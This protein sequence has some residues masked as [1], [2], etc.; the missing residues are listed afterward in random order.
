MR[1]KIP[2]LILGVFYGVSFFAQEVVSTAGSIYNVNGVQLSWTI[3]EPI[4][5]TEDDGNHVLT[6]GFHQANLSV[7]TVEENVRNMFSVYP[8]PVVNVFTIQG[9]TEE[10]VTAVLYD[11][12][13]KLLKQIQFSLSTQVNIEDLSRGVYLLTINQNNKINTYRIIKK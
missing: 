2:L 12:N 6:Q 9:S 7:T 5:S 11:L 4:V 3:G 13:G 8:N 1:R 10:N